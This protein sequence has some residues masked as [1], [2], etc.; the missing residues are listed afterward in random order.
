MQVNAFTAALPRVGV[1]LPARRFAKKLQRSLGEARVVF[2]VEPRLPHS[3]PMLPTPSLAARQE[4]VVSFI[5]A[6]HAAAVAA[7]PTDP[8]EAQAAGLLCCG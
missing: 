3:W 7:A 6:E 4:V 1:L 5:A 8:A 2:H